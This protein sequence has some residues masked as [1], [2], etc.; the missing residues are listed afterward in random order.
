MPLDILYCLLVPT[1]VTNTL[2]VEGCKAIYPITLHLSI[3]VSV[4]SVSDSST[5]ALLLKVAVSMAVLFM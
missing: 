2:F 5:G 3:G 4:M 1:L